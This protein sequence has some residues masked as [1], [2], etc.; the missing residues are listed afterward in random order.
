[1]VVKDIYTYA[2]RLDMN[3]RCIRYCPSLCN[4]PSKYKFTIFIRANVLFIMHSFKNRSV[5]T[6]SQIHSRTS[7]DVLPSISHVRY[8]TIILTSSQNVK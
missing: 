4:V 8:T 6:S 3:F 2:E 7:E 1:M 5:D